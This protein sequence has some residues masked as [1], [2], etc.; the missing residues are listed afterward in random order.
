[1]RAVAALGLPDDVLADVLSGNANQV[2]LFPASRR[3]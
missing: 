1:V 3:P 2:Y